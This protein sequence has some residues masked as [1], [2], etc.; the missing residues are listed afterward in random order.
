MEV[1]VGEA[2]GE[3]DGERKGVE[4]GDW[5]AGFKADLADHRAQLLGFGFRSIQV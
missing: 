1:W 3:I 4:Q 5:H 2:V